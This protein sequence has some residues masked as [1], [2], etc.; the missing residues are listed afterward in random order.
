MYI[1]GRVTAAAALRH[2]RHFRALGFCVTSRADKAVVAAL[3]FEVRMQVVVEHGRR[4]RV[5]GVTS[6]AIRPE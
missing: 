5:T 4:P 1:V 6:G 2:V 3:Q